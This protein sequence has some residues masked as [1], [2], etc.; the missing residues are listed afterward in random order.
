MMH[1]PRGEYNIQNPSMKNGKCK[2]QYPKQFSNYKHI[3][4]IHT[5]IRKEEKMEKKKKQK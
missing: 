1:G 5:H 3:P 2:N 4:Q